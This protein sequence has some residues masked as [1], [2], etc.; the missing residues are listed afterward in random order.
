MKMYA[1]F[2]EKKEAKDQ[3][4]EIICLTSPEKP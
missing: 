2:A 3:T 1:L 4:G